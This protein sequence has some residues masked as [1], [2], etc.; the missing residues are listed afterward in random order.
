MLEVSDTDGTDYIDAA[1]AGLRRALQ[2]RRNGDAHHEAET[3]LALGTALAKGTGEPP[4]TWREAKQMLSQAIQIFARTADRPGQLAV[5]HMHLAN[6][7]RKVPDVRPGRVQSLFRH[8]RAVL[9]SEASVENAFLILNQMEHALHFRMRL[10][11]SRARA[12]LEFAR[13]VLESCGF[14]AEA[15][16]AV[17]CVE[18]L[19]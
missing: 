10:D 18:R 9:G 3:L 19:S 5:A 15:A 8:A 16:R 12:D 14:A 4:P 2:L 1:V 7:L 13:V 6:L 11:R 17:W